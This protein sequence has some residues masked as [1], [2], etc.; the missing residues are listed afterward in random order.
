MAKYKK[1]II[2]TAGIASSIY[3]FLS[4]VCNIW[5]S[6]TPV[7]NPNHFKQLG[8]L[9]MIVSIIIFVGSILLFIKM[10]KK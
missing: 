5:I 7:N 10:N 2:L 1:W 4:S 9:F 3:I 8:L 6:A